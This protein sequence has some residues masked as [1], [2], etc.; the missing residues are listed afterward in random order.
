MSDAAKSNDDHHGRSGPHTLSKSTKQNNQEDE[1]PEG[2][3]E[4][5]QEPR[6]NPLPF[7]NGRKRGPSPEFIDEAK[8]SKNVAL[9]SARRYSA[10]AGPTIEVCLCTPDLKIPR[11]RNGMK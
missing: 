6:L 8:D 2:Q 11:P 5:R 7:H 10:F 4:P 9:S 3:K 1:V